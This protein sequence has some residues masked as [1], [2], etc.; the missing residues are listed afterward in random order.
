M[1]NV[2]REK[3]TQYNLRSKNLLLLPETNV[4]KYGNESIAFRG[5]ILWNYLRNEIKNQASVCP[6]KKSIESCGG[7][8]YNCK[9]CK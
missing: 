6:L 5:S 8:D 9:I 7:E 4:F 1:G 2:F 3:I